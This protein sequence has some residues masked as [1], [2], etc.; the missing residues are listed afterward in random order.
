MKP[1][2]YIDHIRPIEGKIEINSIV[3]SKHYNNLIGRIHNIGNLACTI[4]VLRNINGSEGTGVFSMSRNDMELIKCK[5]T[6][7]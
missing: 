1:T 2:I 3:R 5:I 7:K 4:I 6:I